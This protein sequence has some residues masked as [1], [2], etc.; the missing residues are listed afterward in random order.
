[1]KQRIITGLAFGIISLS[2]IL[3]NQSTQIAFLVIVA[4]LSL[5]EYLKIVGSNMHLVIGL[6]VFALVTG[7]IL[8]YGM[9]IPVHFSLVLAALFAGYLLLL[10]QKSVRK[11]HSSLGF[12]TGTLYITLSF[13]ALISAIK[14]HQFEQLLYIIIFIWIADSGAY[15]V[16]KTIGKRKFAPSISPNKTWEGFLGGGMLSVLAS[17]IISCL[18]SNSLNFQYWAFFA[19]I[20]WLFGAMGDLAESQIKRSFEIK[21][22]GTLLPG[23]GGF[24]DRFD[25][26][27]YCLPF[28]LLVFYYL[29]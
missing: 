9:V 14:N 11:L 22:S 15:F 3:Y 25:G 28:V 1:M 18:D 29:G 2:L 4:L 10:N 8:V 5:Y 26:F 16:G 24:L 19:L 27:V 17:Y 13:A 12:I 20:V 21:D 6:V 7:A 23:H